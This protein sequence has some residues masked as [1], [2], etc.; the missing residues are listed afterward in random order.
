M[1][2]AGAVK[3]AVIAPV[4]AGITDDPQWMS[5]FARHVEVCGFESI[6]VVEH[7]ACAQR[8]GLIP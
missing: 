5:A 6:V 3:F 8:L 4:A 7:T 2:L 1:S